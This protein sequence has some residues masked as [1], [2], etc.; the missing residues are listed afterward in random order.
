[1]SL[2]PPDGAGGALPEAR[3]ARESGHPYRVSAPPV[4]V[5]DTESDA[6]ALRLR[7]LT[8]RTR[9]VG[10]LATLAAV[11]V[12]VTAF[13]HAR[14]PRAGRLPPLPATPRAA[15]A[16][17]DE[18]SARSEAREARM[19]LALTDAIAHAKPASACA[20]DR[21]GIFG[22]TPITRA[23]AGVGALE[24]AVVRRARA[25]LSATRNALVD[26]TSRAGATSTAARSTWRAHEIVYVETARAEPQA[27]AGGTFLPGRAEGVAYVYDFASERVVCAA[28][29]AS[30]SSP[31]L[32]YRMN[33]TAASAP[34]RVD[35]GST[36]QRALDGDLSKRTLEAIASVTGL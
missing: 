17:I 26:G 4:E 5:T 18:A 3:A 31:Q 19:R 28:H 32:P 29:V 21:H 2:R 16:Q 12:F 27:R 25:D 24:S 14:S 36:L 6:Y 13:A 20:V 34:A 1:M 15:I 10:A 33:S 8:R 9:R 30:E 23:D 7:A 22:A 11:G 35:D